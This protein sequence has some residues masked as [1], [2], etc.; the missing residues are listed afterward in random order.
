MENVIHY[1]NAHTLKNVVKVEAKFRRKK[2]FGES[3]KLRCTF[4]DG[5]TIILKMGRTEIL[6][7]IW[8]NPPRQHFSPKKIMCLHSAEVRHDDNSHTIEIICRLSN[9]DVKVITLD[10]AFLM[11]SLSIVQPSFLFSETKALLM[12]CFF[13]R[14]IYLTN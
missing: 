13:S 1:K 4:E 3:I 7:A 12:R 2:F 9:Y 14:I 8:D 10:E 6:T 5:V 11:Y